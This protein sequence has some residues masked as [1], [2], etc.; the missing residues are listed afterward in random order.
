[1]DIR[2]AYTRAQNYMPNGN[3]VNVNLTLTAQ[4]CSPKKQKDFT[5]P[6]IF[7]LD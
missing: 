1:M 2:F 7:S 5:I 4:N 3:W 6:Q